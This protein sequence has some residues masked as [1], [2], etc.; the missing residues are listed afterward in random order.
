MHGHMN[1]KFQE[2]EFTAGVATCQQTPKLVESFL[3]NDQRDAQILFCVY[4]Y[5]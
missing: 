5:L 1:V 3:V 2:Q 4:F